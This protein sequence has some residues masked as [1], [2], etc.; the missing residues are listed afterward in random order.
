MAQ[1]SSRKL[2]AGA[3]VRALRQSHSLTQAAFAERLGVSTSYLNQIENNQRSVSAS[4][5]LALADA[6]GIDVASLAAD[7]TDRVL[8]DLKEVF[9]DPVFSATTITS[10]EIKIAASNTPAITDAL[11]TLYRAY[12]QTNER[13][14][15]FDNVLAQH[16][17]VL[18]PFPYEEVRDFFH[19]SGNYI[20]PLD[21]A[22]EEL[23]KTFADSGQQTADALMSRLSERHGVRAVMGDDNLE[24]DA[25]RVF[26]AK[27]K[28]LSL[29]PASSRATHIF[30]LAHQIAL[31]E[32]GDLIDSL[33]ADATLK[34]ADAR[35]VC[36]VSLA[37]YFAG[38]VMLP[39]T[40]FRRAAKDLRHDLEQLV[41]RFGASLEQVAHRL[42]TLQR[43]GNKGVPFFFVRVDQAGNI[44]KRH[45]ATKFQFARFS[46]GCPLWNV[47]R[48]FET[49]DRIIRQ[50][51]ETPDGIRYLCLARNLTKRSGGFRSPIRRYAIAL[52]C[53]IKHADQL[54]YADDLDIANNHVYE[55]IGVSCRICE[56]ND[57]QQRAVPPIGSSLQIDHSRRRVVPFSIKD[58][59]SRT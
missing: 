18:E 56:R 37:N 47:H 45:S 31:L 51:A 52:G 58:G 17:G 28:I 7:E 38:A 55:P 50:L 29:N 9:S 40:A 10:Q 32:Q 44:T 13:I 23:A 22:A 24:L 26:N 4:V 19:Y 59:R 3:R 21:K 54:I 5:I 6:F 8:A 41:H 11:L 39:Y 35:A 14:A 36:K 2:F 1:R 25:L 33:I 49:P 48:A 43:P 46:G 20:D 15:S 12:A 27:S 30:Q 34:T 53:E 57:C 42:S 16:E